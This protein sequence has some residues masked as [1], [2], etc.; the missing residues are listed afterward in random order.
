MIDY[1]DRSVFGIIFSWTGT[2]LSQTYPD[3]IM[4]MLVSC[5]TY[6]LMQ[7]PGIDLGPK[8]WP[9]GLIHSKKALLFP[10]AFLLVYRTGVSYKRFFEGRAHVG[11]MVK[12]CRELARGI[13]TY[14]VGT[15]GK[16]ELNKANCHRLL[17]A[18]TIAVR[19]SCRK[20]EGSAHVQ[21]SEF[22]T[23]SEYAKC[24]EVKKNFPVLILMWLGQ[25]IAAF[26]G[27]LLFPRSMDFMER[28]VGQL[29]EAWMGMQKLATTPFPFPYIQLLVSLLYIY[30]YTNAIVLTLQYEALAIPIS[31]G[32]AFALFGLHTIGSELEDPFGEEAN[33]L[34]LETFESTAMK[35]CAVL[36]PPLARPEMIEPVGPGA[37]VSMNG[38]APPAFCQSCQGT[39]KIQG[40]AC[41]SCGGS[42]Q[43]TMEVKTDQVALNFGPGSPGGSPKADYSILDEKTMK[44]QLRVGTSLETLSP[45][46]Q[47]MFKDFF[48]RY[49]VS[50]NGLIDNSKELTQLVTNLA[51]SLKLSL[52]LTALLTEVEKLGNNVKMDVTQ[53]VAWFLPQVQTILLTGV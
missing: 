34:S 44:Q 28:D 42:G 35:S 48:T 23:S 3:C 38:A 13:S 27:A 18:Y 20:I 4:A 15:D 41:P 30:V 33:D 32:I 10:A 14:V 19:L 37:H 52:G 16:T 51:F 47:Q 45:P 6:G 17:K 29:M 36:L 53:F 31:F 39:G 7:V 26:D 49:D 5:A 1:A 50:A 43:T 12:Q 21:L 9:V 11:V 25:A 22:L 2:T 24:K 8:T 46:M 40:A